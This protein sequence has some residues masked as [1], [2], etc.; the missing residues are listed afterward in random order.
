MSDF[1]VW[2]IAVGGFD[3][4][5]SYM[6]L[7]ES[8]AAVLIDP[9]GDIG[10][11]KRIF[12]N[13][14]DVVPTAILLT[15]GHH[16]HVSGVG[17]TGKFF[18]APVMGHPDCSFQLDAALVDRGRVDMGG[19]AFIECVHSPG[20][21]PDSV[22][23]RLSDDS[24]IFT[25]DT[26]FVDWCGYCRAREMFD[27]MRNVIFPLSDSNTVFPGHDYGHAPTSPLGVEKKHNP[28]LA[29]DNFENFKK[30]L[31]DL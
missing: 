8:G 31:V 18:D 19:G 16:D 22:V 5:F 6:V 28:F 7:H 14:G 12:E 25:G 13:A 30:A 24:G 27:T 29:A 9:C 4:N 1:K 3:S 2:Q 26:L 15:H 11:I 17:E 10:E 20:H 21:T 23:Y